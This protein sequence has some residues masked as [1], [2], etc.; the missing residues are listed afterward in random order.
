MRLGTGLL[1][2]ICVLLVFSLACFVGNEAREHGHYA[3]HNVSSSL[4]Y[5]VTEL[6]EVN[7]SMNA[8][9]VARVR[10]SNVITIMTNFMHNIAMETAKF[11][12]EYGYTHPNDYASISDKLIV[13][14]YVY[15]AYLFL[16]I[17]PF[18]IACA[19]LIGVGVRNCVRRYK[20][21]KGG[22]YE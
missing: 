11:G 6:Q 13:L 12:V 4:S 16:L 7:E 8:S 2:L 1:V 18:I 14:M 9:V 17:S 15:L 20:K 19:Y 5:N 10:L 3:L 21:H 22:C